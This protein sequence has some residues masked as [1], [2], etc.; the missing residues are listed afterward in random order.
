MPREQLNERSALSL[1]SLLDLKPRAPWSAAG[2]PL[3][4]IT[5]M[6]EFFAKQYGKKYAPNSQETVRRF[7]FHQF[8]QAGL[9]LKNPDKPRP[10]NSPDCV[11]QIEASALELLRTFGG[12]KWN[13]N[14]SAYCA[15]HKTLVERYAAER[16]MKTVRVTVRD[17]TA[18]KL[19]PGAH[20]ILIKEVIEGF[21]PR[22]T[23]GARVV[24]IGDAGDK[25]A[26][27]E[28]EYLG[29]LGIRI[30][31]HG[32]MP[33]IVIHDAARNWL[34]LVEAVTSHGPT[35]AKRHQELKTLFRSTSCGLV[36]VTAFLDR[37]TMSKYL[38][39][40]A[41]ETEVWV[42]ESPSHLIHFD[43]ERFLGPYQETR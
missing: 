4:G 34:V 42:A 23:P 5:P 26:A 39:D 38:G 24:Y 36:F 3:M 30:D 20:N 17:G 6:M 15:T 14:L 21:C 16:I 41:W 1:Q 10:V 43:G 27:W 25:F 13:R 40:I 33:D 31:K 35:N 7:T 11:Y 32:K 37:R 29:D 12:P 28:K 22:F 18:V 2:K 19:S 8:E 9:I